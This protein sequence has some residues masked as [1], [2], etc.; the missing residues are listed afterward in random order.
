MEDGMESKNRKY[1]M[2][3]ISNSVHRELHEAVGGEKEGN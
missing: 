1:C 2:D 3:T